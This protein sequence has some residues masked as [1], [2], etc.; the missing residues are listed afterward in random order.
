MSDAAIIT[1][2]LAAFL[3]GMSIGVWIG[4]VHQQNANL[5]DR[6]IGFTYLGVVSQSRTLGV[7]D[8]RRA[9]DPHRIPERNEV[10]NEWRRNGEHGF[11]R[12]A[13]DTPEGGG[14]RPVA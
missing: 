10:L 13:D 6:M 2:V 9:F 12:R 4:R 5:A 3:L 8:I 7:E 1:L 11:T 14:P